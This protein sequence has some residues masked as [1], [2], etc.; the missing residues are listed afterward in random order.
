[1]FISYSASQKKRCTSYN[2]LIFLGDVKLEI[3][4]QPMYL[5]PTVIHHMF[6]V[7]LL[8]KPIIHVVNTE[9]KIKHSV[10]SSNDLL[11][12]NYTWETSILGPFHGARVNGERL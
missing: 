7:C 12:H 10:V 1:M 3:C 2:L 9:A 4:V 11:M 5:L 8:H 6:H